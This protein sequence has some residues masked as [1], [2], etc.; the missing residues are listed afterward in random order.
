[1]AGV[2]LGIGASQTP[3]KSVPWAEWPTLGQTQEASPHAPADLDGQLKPA[4]FEG[5]HAAAQAAV[6]PLGQVARAANVP[7]SLLKGG[8]SEALSW[9]AVSGA[10]EH[11]GMT[12]VDDS[13]GYRT[14]TSTRRAMAL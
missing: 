5:C 1:M 2:V 14:P 7:R 6:K 11:L 12:L 4:A 13:P 10:T 9:I 3:R 8:T